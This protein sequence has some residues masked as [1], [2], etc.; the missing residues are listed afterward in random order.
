[1]W[2]VR[3][4]AQ[5]MQ[6]TMSSARRWALGSVPDATYA[7]L[8]AAANPVTQ[9]QPHP[10]IASYRCSMCANTASACSREHMNALIINSSS[11]LLTGLESCRQLLGAALGNAIYSVKFGVFCAGDG[12][13]WGAV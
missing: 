10:M 7:A 4:R 9:E 12:D 6:Q 5:I 1:M 2:M 13:V 11:S 3:S 8:V